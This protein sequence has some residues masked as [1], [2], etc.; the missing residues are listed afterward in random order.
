VQEARC[1]VANVVIRAPQPANIPLACDGARMAI[2]ES[3]AG[4]TRAVPALRPDARSQSSAMFGL[5]IRT[6]VRIITAWDWQD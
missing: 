3:V 2:A 6:I 4:L 5:T 1:D